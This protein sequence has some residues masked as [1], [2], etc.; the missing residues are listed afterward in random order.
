MYSLHSIT[1][2]VHVLSCL[3][4]ELNIYKLYCVDISEVK[5]YENSFKIFIDANCSFRS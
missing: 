3:W 4:A 1:Y 2:N 5:K